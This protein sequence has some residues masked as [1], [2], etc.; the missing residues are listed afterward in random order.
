MSTVRIQVRRGTASQWSSVNPILAA[1]EMG[2]ESDTNLFKFGNGSAAWVDLAYAN[3]SDVAITE[4]S[5]DAINSALSLGAGLTKTY[6]D[7]A[8]TIEITVDS[9][10]VA[11]KSYVDSAITGLSNTVDAG[12]LQVTDRGAAGG[13]ASL[14]SSGKVPA[15]ELDIRETIE[16]TASNL[17]VAGR[18]ID[19]I[20]NDTSNTLTLSLAEFAGDGIVFDDDPSTQNRTIK[21]ADS[22][23]PA[24]SIQTGTVTADAIE[25]ITFE[26]TSN[27]TVGGNLVVSGN[28]TVN[29]TSTSVNSTNYTVDDPMI[30]IGDGNQSNT[31]D[32]GLVAAFNNGT[33][34]HAGLVRDASDG[35]WKL[36]SGV[37]TEPGTTVDFSTYTKDTLEV[38][39]LS[40]DSA[41]IGN[42][43]NAEIQYLHGVTS[44]VQTQIDSK[45]S[46]TTASSTYAPKNNAAFTGTFSVANGAISGDALADN[47]VTSGKI[48]ANSITSDKI[49]DGAIV[50]ADISA[51]AAISPTKIA[52]TAIALSDV[53]V[54]TS[55]MI[56]NGTILDAD[57]AS[58]AAIV[59]TKIAG[60]AVTLDDLGTVTS[61]M[62]AGNIAQTKISTLVPDLA[63]KAPSDSPTFTGTV[64]LPSTTSIGTVT[65]TEIG[66]VDG[67]T[68]SIQTQIN[69]ATS[70]TSSHAALTTNVH[71]ISDT[72]AL[73]T[74]AG[75]ETLTNKTLTLGANTVTGTK[76]QFN[77]AM[78]DAD[79]ATIAGTET[80]TNKT[81]TSPAITSPT[82]IVKADVGLGNVD[83]TSDANKP[84]S[85]ATQTAL[86]LKANIA[87]PTFTGTLTAADA[88]I[89]GNL[90]VTGTTTTVSATNLSISDPLIYMGTGNS[91][92]ASDLGIVGHFN[93]GTYQHTGLIRDHADGKWKLFSGVTTEPGSATIDLTGAT[94]DTLKIGPLEG[95]TASHTTISASGLITATSGVAFSD[96]TQTKQGVPSQTAIVSKTADYTLSALT[97]RD[98]L[99]EVNSASAVTITVPPA[100]SVNYPVG[101]SIDILRVGAGAVTV[102]AGAGVTLN[103][104]PGNKLRAQWSGA[105]LFKRASDSWV[106]YGDLSA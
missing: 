27:A 17:I 85:T 82:G 104:T 18:G 64:V 99:I 95:T 91:A 75:S 55:A 68:S 39:A 56:A 62:L 102:A 47:A 92:N 38:G 80:L 84:V 66:Y 21:L 59:K 5:Q 40:A 19:K 57:I 98:S 10:V 8:N 74:K 50:N 65:A 100:S 90:T 54:I 30:Y 52:G 26:S 24:T 96:G 3:N 33:Y 37:I 20:Y 70:A 4:I 9:S 86:D 63:A 83:N 72:A 2:V 49:A 60:T 43:T 73:A 101:T 14:N 77:A 61:D 28:I 79:F 41:K 71:G 67:V 105:T 44:G 58:N 45:L 103:Y 29:G 89:T 69:S 23:N 42:T 31:L 32:L 7:G 94:Y 12:Y 53:G 25:T 15:S 87:S 88:T 36:F 6:N 35:K 106:V 78:T 81:L 1:G 46:T 97:E 34:Q 76:A 22:I 11:L 16:D 51:T 48:A 93:N 13:V